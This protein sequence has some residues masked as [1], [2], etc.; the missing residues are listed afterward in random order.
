MVT[1]L[2]VRALPANAGKNPQVD[3]VQNPLDNPLYSSA[4]R[5]YQNEIQSCPIG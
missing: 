1:L 3:S 5:I 2:I 4:N